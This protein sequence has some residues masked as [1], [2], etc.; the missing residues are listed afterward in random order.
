MRFRTIPGLS[1]AT[2]ELSIGSWKTFETMEFDDIV[3]VIAACFDAGINFID[4]CR[5]GRAPGVPGG[6]PTTEVIVGR[7]LREIG[8]PRQE[9]AIADKLWWDQYPRLSLREQLLKALRRLDQEY[10]DL[11]Y[12]DRPDRLAVAHPELT[13][14]YEKLVVSIA[15]EMAALKQDGLIKAYG[16]A[17]S[18]PEAIKRIFSIV[19][20]HSLLAPAVAQIR[21]S[22]V[23]PEASV[24]PELDA[25]HL[26]HGL[27]LTATTTMAGGILSGKY[28]ESDAHDGGRLSN[29]QS[30]LDGRSMDIARSLAALASE[31]RLP[32]T[33]L[34][35][36][37]PLQNPAVASVVFGA[38]TVNQ[39]K[40]NLRAQEVDALGI[41]AE[42]LALASA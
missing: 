20:V 30:E 4:D 7:A 23:E 31:N 39:V 10:I 5:Y 19:D 13:F 12:I 42:I 33:A 38:R 26:S 18:K 2:S 16:F 21:Y 15:E 17:N 40:E 1:L 41:N 14:D 36:S 29:K 25:L 6:I 28:L 32:A 37:F 27:M 34:A 35:M 11:L 24:S 8:R 22:L 9:Y 3:A